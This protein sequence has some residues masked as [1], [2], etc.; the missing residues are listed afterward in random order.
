MQ[1]HLFL[2][3]PSNIVLLFTMGKQWTERIIQLGS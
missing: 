2:L 3:L 1:L